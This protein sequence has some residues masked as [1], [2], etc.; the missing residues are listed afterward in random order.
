MYKMKQVSIFLAAVFALSLTVFAQANYSGSWELDKSKSKLD[1]RA[2]KSI[3]AQ[4]LIVSQTANSLTVEVKTKTVSSAE[5]G[6]G[7]PVDLSVDEKAKPPE[8]SKDVPMAA[9]P[10]GAESIRK[11]SVM[12]VG[13]DF[14]DGT[15]T[16][17]LDS[18][19]TKAQQEP[20]MG[21]SAVNR[22]KWGKD[23]SLQLS[24]TKT[25]SG[26]NGE[27]TVSLKE[28]WTLSA[29]GKVLNV[30]R[31]TDTLNGKT[32]SESVYEKGKG[33]SPKMSQGSLSDTSP[34]FSTASPEPNDWGVI[35][36][37][38]PPVPKPVLP[39]KPKP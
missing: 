20:P 30:K 32:S 14:G 9:P 1:E 31:E 8:T 29:D 15:T 26:P 36:D 2:G 23:G 3:E 37:K 19:D 6:M 28:S 16:Y 35:N 4:T 10:I 22:A 11:G 33:S 25:I 13:S 18:K 7:K 39:K 34:T 21:S 12:A 27:M 24:Q 17:S 5:D 38:A